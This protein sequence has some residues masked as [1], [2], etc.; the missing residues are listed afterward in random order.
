M[1]VG[2]KEFINYDLSAVVCVVANVLLDGGFDEDEAIKIETNEDDFGWMVGATGDFGRFK[3]NDTVA[4]VTITLMQGSKYN[5]L[6]AAQR[7][8]DTNTPGGAGVGAFSV[9][10]L[11]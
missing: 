6:L 11:L 9:K 7:A 10:D 8:L 3:T 4:K 5:D 2:Q 1:G